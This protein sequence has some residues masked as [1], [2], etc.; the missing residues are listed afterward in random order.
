MQAAELLGEDE[1]N[2]ILFGYVFT[3]CYFRVVEVAT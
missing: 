1:T 2:E 3:G